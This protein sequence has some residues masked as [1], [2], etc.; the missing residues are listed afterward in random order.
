MSSGCSGH[1]WPDL[2]SMAS[3]RDPDR[4]LRLGSPPPSERREGVPEQAQMAAGLC[5]QLGPPEFA[6]AG[7][8]AAERPI[9]LGP[10]GGGVLAHRAGI[11]APFGADVH[12]DGRVKQAARSRPL[13]VFE[14][15]ALAPQD[16]IEQALAPLDLV[17]S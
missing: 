6:E 17:Q 16:G 14:R 10:A 11:E 13:R 1:A 5:D 3:L 12:L 4:Q 2:K 7:P 15:A 9:D 8:V